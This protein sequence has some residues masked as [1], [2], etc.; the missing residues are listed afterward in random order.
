MSVIDE[1]RSWVTSDLALQGLLERAADEIKQLNQ[2]IYQLK[3]PGTDWDT[4]MSHLG[5]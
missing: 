3:N 4:L 2:E 1:L 5:T